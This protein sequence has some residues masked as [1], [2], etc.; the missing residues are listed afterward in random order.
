MGHLIL[1]D[2]IDIRTALIDFLVAGKKERPPELLPG[3]HFN[4]CV[5][6]HDDF[7][8]PQSCVCARCYNACR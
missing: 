1:R 8:E 5:K 7:V 3:L 2:D 6:N 4:W